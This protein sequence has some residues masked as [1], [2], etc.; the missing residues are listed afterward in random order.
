ML[1]QYASDLHLEFSENRAWLKAHPMEPAA[2]VL[3]LA[4]DV[5]PLHQAYGAPGLFKRLTQG[6]REVI[7]LPGNHEYY[8]GRIEDKD[9]D[10]DIRLFR[11]IRIVNNRSVLYPGVRILCT[12]LWTAIAQMNEGALRHNMND[13]HAIRHGSGLLMPAHTT[14]FHAHCLAWLKSELTKPFD[15]C[16][17]VATH[18]VPTLQHYP[19]EYV[20]SALN[21]AFAVELEELIAGSGALAWIYGHHHRNIPAFMIGGTRMFTNQVGYVAQNEQIGF[22][23]AAVIGPGMHR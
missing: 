19:P 2:E 18:H 23:P 5:L 8:G 21:Q 15:G 22:D 6:F 16:T 12:T 20:G 17:I 4:G 9:L 11:N 10:T 14:R 1:L 3:L 13:Y 7:W